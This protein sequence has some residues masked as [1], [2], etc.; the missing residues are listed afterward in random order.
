M[1]WNSWC[2]PEGPLQPSVCNLLGKDPCSDKMVRSVADAMV[3][4]GM[5]KLGYEYL[6]LDDCWSTKERDASGDLVADAKAFPG[7]ITATADYLHSKGLKMGVYTSVG[8]TTC[9]GDR[10]GTYGHWV[11]DAT[12]LAGWGVDFIKMDHCGAKNGTDVEL[13]GNMSAALNATGR[14]V[15]FSLCSWGEAAVWDWGHTVAQSFRVQMDHLPFW[16]LGTT[17]SGAGYG[18]G[19]L[20]II[21]WM[22]TLQPSKWTKQ[23]GW[24]DPGWL[25]AQF[26]CAREVWC[27]ARGA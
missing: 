11:Q 20:E 24:L 26:R 13:Y 7:G 27:V 23:Y 3:S 9:K 22:S 16:K 1:G 10:P 12:T 18:Q 21:N 4:Q 15:F 5:D 25:W 8:A 14:P 2:T 17:G 19:V 6:V